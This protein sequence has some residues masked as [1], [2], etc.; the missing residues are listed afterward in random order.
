VIL[1]FAKKKPVFSLGHVGLAVEVGEQAKVENSMTQNDP[2]V[3]LGI[4]AVNKKRLH[5]VSKKYHKLG[6][7]EP[8][9]VSFP[10]KIGL[11]AW[12]K[13]REEIIKIHCHM[14][15]R[16]EKP[17]EGGVA[18]TDKFGTKPDCDG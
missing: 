4:V 12:S 14:D 9:Q 8:G 13:S 3:D 10:P 2:A 15:A 7:L 5:G 16:V 1:V 11:N 18:P 6:H 17:T